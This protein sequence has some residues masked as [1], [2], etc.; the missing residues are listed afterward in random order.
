MIFDPPGSVQSQ[1]VAELALL[2]VIG[3]TTVY[4]VLD[5]RSFAKNGNVFVNPVV[6]DTDAT[7]S[8]HTIS[9]IDPMNL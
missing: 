3:V 6:F 1:G 5:R 8:C 4:S 7:F 2:S 9:H